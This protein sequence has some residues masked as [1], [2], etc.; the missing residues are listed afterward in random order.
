MT[1]NKV[2]PPLSEV[3]PEDLDFLL[4]DFA[5]CRKQLALER[6]QS[7]KLRAEKKDAE[8][9]LEI[10]AQSGNRWMFRALE[11]MREGQLLR[12]EKL[13]LTIPTTQSR[14]AIGR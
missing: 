3:N 14:R 10:V 11:A 2:A 4:R 1:A 5:D 13:G 8:E 9:R 6:Q 7:A 12:E